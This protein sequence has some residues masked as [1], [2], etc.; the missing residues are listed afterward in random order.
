MVISVPFKM[1]GVWC[2]THLEVTV[3]D[4]GLRP[5]KREG[6]PGLGLRPSSWSGIAS[7]LAVDGNS[8]L[9][10]KRPDADEPA[11]LAHRPA[12]DQTIGTEDG[13]RPLEIT[14]EG[15]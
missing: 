2:A 6:A 12:T 7:S 5:S 10:L 13:T 3:P 15:P 8:R 4:Y 11:V 1:G 14:T 9:P